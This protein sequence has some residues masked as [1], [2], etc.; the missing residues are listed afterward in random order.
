M[1]LILFIK[2]FCRINSKDQNKHKNWYI[3]VLDNYYKQLNLYWMK[4]DEE[5]MNIIDRTIKIEI[6]LYLI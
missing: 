1:L 5:K 3:K 4:R 2:Y 6:L